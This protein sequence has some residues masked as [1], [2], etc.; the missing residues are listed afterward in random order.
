VTQLARASDRQRQR[1]LC[2]FDKELQRHRVVV[3]E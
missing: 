1:L 2:E 3:M